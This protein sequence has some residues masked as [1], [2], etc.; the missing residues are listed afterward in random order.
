MADTINDLE[1]QTLNVQAKA[2]AAREQA[3]MERNRAN[4]FNQPED[5]G[6]REA[7]NR[8]ADLLDQ[9]AVVFDNE[10]RD[11]E[12]KREQVIGR[13]NDL[14]AQRQV[15]NQEMTDKIAAIDNELTQIQGSSSI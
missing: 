7:H 8:Q 13:I 12:A 11:I 5:Q 9:R 1:K 6:N 4:Q 10:L 3:Q 2:E 15:L 14:K